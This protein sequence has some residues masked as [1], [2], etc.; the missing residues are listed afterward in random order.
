MS[1]F[2]DTFHPSIKDQ[3]KVRQD[4]MTNRTSQNL[5][6]LNSRNAWIRIS[7]AVNVYKKGIPITSASLVDPASYDNTLAKQYILQGGTLYNGNLRSG[8]TPGYTQGG[9]YS[10]SGSL[11]EPYRLGIRPMPG[12][13]SVDVKSKSAYGSL[14]EATVNFQCWDIKQL[15]DLELLYMRPGYTVLLEWGWSPYLNNKNEYITSVD[16]TDIIDKTWDKEELFKRQYARSTDGVYYKDDGT[17]ISVTGYQGNS[18]SMFGYV[19]NYSWKARMDGG[20]DCT[21]NIISIGEVIESLKV[22]YSPLNT[23]LPITTKGL[24]SPNI[25]ID[26]TG[27]TELSSS[28]SQ[29]ILAGI[30]YELREIVRKKAG[31]F[32][33]DSLGAAATIATTPIAGTLG[34]VIAGAITATNTEQGAEDVNGTSYLF[35]DNQYKFYYDVYRRTLNIAGGEH[36]TSRTNK[37]GES[38]EQIYITLETLTNI[39]NNYVLLQDTTNKKPFASISVLEPQIGPPIQPDPISGSGYL[40]ALAHPLEISVD[41]TVCLIKNRLWIDGLNIQLDRDIDANSGLPVAPPRYGTATIDRKWWEDIAKLVNDANNGNEQPLIKKVRET[42]GTGDQA[43]EN[44][45]EIQRWFTVNEG[46]I[47]NIPVIKDRI[48]INNTIIGNTTIGSYEHFYDLLNEGLT[49]S[50]INDILG[51]RRPNED[52]PKYSAATKNPYSL[53]VERLEEAKQKLKEYKEKGSQGSKYLD[54]L[55]RPYFIDNGDYTKELGIIGNI[56]VNINMLYNLSVDKTLASQDKKEKNEINLYDFLKNI[57][58][59]ISTS[60][61]NVNNFDIHVDPNGST[62]RI[63]DVNYVDK[64]S[65]DQAYDNAVELQVHNLNSIVRS[66]SLESKIFPEQATQVAIGAQVGGGALGIDS[67]TLVDYNRLIRD[68]IIPIKNAPTDP[69]ESEN[70]TTLSTLTN[71]LSTLIP[72]FDESI[73]GSA[74]GVNLT[75]GTYNVDETGKY[76][77]ALRDIIQFFTSISKSKIRGKAIIPT[78]LSLEM[79]GIGGIIIGNIF[80]INTDILP[81]GYKDIDGVRLGY[82]VTGIGHSLNNNDW[83]TKLDSQFILLDEPI[84]GKTINFGK[85]LILNVTP[86]TGGELTVNNVVRAYSGNYNT[87]FVSDNLTAKKAAETYIG[88]VLSDQEW[89]ELVAATFAEASANQEERAHVMGVILNRARIRK[90]TISFI[91]RE[92]NQ[93]QAV[94]GT[95]NN[96]RSPSLNYVNG[97]DKKS[98]NSI[99]TATINILNRVPKNYTKFTSNNPKAY[100]EPGTNIGYLDELKKTGKVIGQT[101]FSS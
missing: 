5:Q 24:L 21:V 65:S 96:G 84:Q 87:N 68:R 88:R 85:D 71:A 20:Y 50:T 93:F 19:K 51:I 99:Y 28:Y 64:M 76:T 23:K 6:Y 57:L 1:I 59:K 17:Q 83:V 62:A 67:T 48:S 58:S 60:I 74:L 13:T 55:T 54:N 22:N 39:L 35:Y 4:A 98:A 97:P 2:K 42:V 92:R 43:I 12:I 82:V 49:Q 8:L 100:K 25:G 89:N 15:E 90:K 40:L 45:K 53:D 101:I 61:G 47:R 3:L 79:D 38:D 81:R 18:E 69:T 36:P 34:G 91:L 29:N 14:R 77:G 52:D 94:T 46:K 75:D 78:T 44:L 56:Y 95:S 63:I 16:Y 11:G 73:P 31:G 9:A 66:Y 72:F 37:I 10:I 80:K 27:M 7:S 41:P 70:K 86:G 32:G 26:A 30:F 33:A